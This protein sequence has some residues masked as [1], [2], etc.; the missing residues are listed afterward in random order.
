MSCTVL[1]RKASLYLASRDSTALV[2]VISLLT[3]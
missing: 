1:I 2:T 3:P